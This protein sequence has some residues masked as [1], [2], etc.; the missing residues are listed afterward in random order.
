MKPLLAGLVLMSL[1]GMAVA[2]DTVILLHGLARSG[3]P[4]QK[5]AEAARGEGHSVLNLEYPST[6]ASI[7][8]LAASHL[9][10]AVDQAVSAG[11][12]RIHFITHSMGG[13][14]VRQFLASRPLPQLG[15][16][17]MLGPPNRGSELVD[18]LGRYAPFAWV[19]GPAGHQLGTGPD[20]LPNRLG[21]VS[22]PVGIIAGTR[23]YNPLYSSLIEGPDDGKV[24]VERAKLEG[25]QDFLV[26]PVNHTFMMGDAHVIRQALRFLREGR[27]EHPAADPQGPPAG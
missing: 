24:G 5:L 18:R 23:S 26:L 4:M 20:S 3:K 9:A 17:V 2:Q 12:A 10:P 8:T 7:E 13:I 14:L 19:N 22:Y 21:A 25:M 16:V 27:F 6:S 1:A 11:A 15:R